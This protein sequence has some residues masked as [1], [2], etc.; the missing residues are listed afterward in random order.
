L[1]RDAKSRTYAIMW[2]WP[3]M[4]K[5]TGA[6][7][8]LQ[9]KRAAWIAKHPLKP[10]RSIEEIFIRNE[11]LVRLYPLTTK[12]RKEKSKHLAVEFVL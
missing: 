10:G 11:E 2:D 7:T 9:K 6:Q 3:F 4:K 12:E 5:K 1:L 8:Q